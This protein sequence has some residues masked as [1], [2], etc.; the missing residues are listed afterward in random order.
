MSREERINMRR[1]ER[2]RGD[3]MRD[4][5]VRTPAGHPPSHRD[6]QPACQP[7]S[8][9]TSQGDFH[10]CL[11]LMRSVAACTRVAS[12]CEGIAFDYTMV[13]FGCKRNVFL[14]IGIAFGY[15]GVIFYCTRAIFLSHRGLYLAALGIGFAGRG[16][17]WRVG[18]TYW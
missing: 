13:V 8:Q 1:E 7:A 5:S 14:Y 17:T 3:D 10:V 12:G 18:R 2:R 4:S 6:S 15:P 16:R 11:L 9:P